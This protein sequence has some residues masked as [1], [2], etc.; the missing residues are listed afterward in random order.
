MTFF[1]VL[2]HETSVWPLKT[3]WTA[4]QFVRN[5]KNLTLGHFWGEKVQNPGNRSTFWFENQNIVFRDFFRTKLA[6]KWPKWLF[7]SQMMPWKYFRTKNIYLKAKYRYFF[8]FLNIRNFWHLKIWKLATPSIGGWKWS[9][10]HITS[11]MAFP[12]TLHDFSNF[13][14]QDLAEKSRKKSKNRLFFKH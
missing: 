13:N 10:D 9:R 8:S 1:R 4:S 12:G 14:F 7:R 3:N 2:K 5:S 11:E 6:A